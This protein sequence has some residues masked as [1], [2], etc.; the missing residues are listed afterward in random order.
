MGYR[1]DEATIS[2]AI[3]GKEERERERGKKA[4]ARACSVTRRLKI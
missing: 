1:T 3:K 2:S 4:A